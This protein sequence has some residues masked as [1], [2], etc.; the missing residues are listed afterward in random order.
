MAQE[1][2]VTAYT[3]YEVTW[4][5]IQYTL[6][7]RQCPN[8]LINEVQSLYWNTKITAAKGE[9]QDKGT[10]FLFLTYTLYTGVDEDVTVLEKGTSP[11]YTATYPTDLN[12]Q[13]TNCYNPSLFLNYFISIWPKYFLQ[14]LV[15]KHFKFRQTATVIQKNEEIQFTQCSIWGLPNFRMSW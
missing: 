13:L 14:S 7:V 3:F 9:G 2:Q 12:P 1:I 15:S 10:F 6:P 8:C 11:I 5:A 4:S